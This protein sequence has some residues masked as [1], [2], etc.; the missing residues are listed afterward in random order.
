MEEESEESRQDLM[1][2]LT[3]I[4]LE[5]QMLDSP[6]KSAKCMFPEHSAQCFCLCYLFY[7]ISKDPSDP[8]EDG[9]LQI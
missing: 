9:P 2:A 8:V 6:V 7:F 5:L 4:V 3:R 1:A